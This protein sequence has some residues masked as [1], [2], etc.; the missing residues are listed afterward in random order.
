MADWKQAV[1]RR[2]PMVRDAIAR[3]LRVPRRIAWIDRAIGDVDYL[4]DCPTVRRHL[5]DAHDHQLPA[6][7][8][9]LVRAHLATCSRC[10]QVD[11][12][13]R[14]TVSM[15]GDLREP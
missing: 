12:S 15:L 11:A 13:L 6:W 8:H 1:K 14:D 4:L 7:K 10:P 3:A 9:S 2:A 5:S